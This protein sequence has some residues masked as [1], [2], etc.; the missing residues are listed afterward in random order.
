MIT[1]NDLK[2]L[3][4]ALSEA[5][6][7]WA[8]DEN[9]KLELSR[10]QTRE[11]NWYVQTIETVEAEDFFYK[12][13]DPRLWASNLGEDLYKAVRVA[14]TYAPRVLSEKVWELELALKIQDEV[15][16]ALG[17]GDGQ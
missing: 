11:A 8:Q 6:R 12:E 2:A 4:A 14:M 5:A 3:R 7:A 16:K 9:P 1:Q 15:V 17:L 13:V 10:G